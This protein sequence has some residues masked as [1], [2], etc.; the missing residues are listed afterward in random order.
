[1]DPS[2]L[3]SFYQTPKQK[4]R[5]RMGVEIQYYFFINEDFSALISD[6]T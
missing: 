4:V 3:L 2:S 5:N 1:M 6:N